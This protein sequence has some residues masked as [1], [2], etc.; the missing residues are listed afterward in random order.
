MAGP[1]TVLCRNRRFQ[2]YFR[3]FRVWRRTPA[4]SSTLQQPPH[5]TF[6]CDAVARPG[7]TRI[8]QYVSGT[9]AESE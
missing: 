7:S 9:R 3:P 4:D 1:Q 5:V 2:H 6:E 8:P